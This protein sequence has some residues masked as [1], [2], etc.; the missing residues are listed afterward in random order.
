MN[1]NNNAELA[2]LQA[3]LEAEYGPNLNGKVKNCNKCNNFS[4]E[5]CKAK[6][7][8]EFVKLQTKSNNV[9]SQTASTC[10]QNGCTNPVGE[11]EIICSKCYNS[12]EGGSKKKL[13][14]KQKKQLKK[15]ILLYNKIKTKILNNK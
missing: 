11:D 6:L 10:I 9:I 8:A 3:E 15:I 4:C 1:N 12:L 14:I 7:E 2:K 13:T 5:N